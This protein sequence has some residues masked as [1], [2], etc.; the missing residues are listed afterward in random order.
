[1]NDEEDKYLGQNGWDDTEDEEVL[2]DNN[3]DN[4]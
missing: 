3:D 4:E 2:G 1:M